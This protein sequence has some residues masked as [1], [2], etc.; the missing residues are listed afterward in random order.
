MII[1]QTQN[2]NSLHSILFGTH[3]NSLIIMSDRLIITKPLPFRYCVEDFEDHWTNSL[4]IPLIHVQAT[5]STTCSYVHFIHKFN[6]QTR[7]FIVKSWINFHQTGNYWISHES[8]KKNKSLDI[9]SWV[10][11]SIF[12]ILEDIR[13]HKKAKSDSATNQLG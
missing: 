9:E 4:N 8:A 11:E 2:W 12:E 10:A 6:M 1:V 5:F 7:I 13:G 3:F